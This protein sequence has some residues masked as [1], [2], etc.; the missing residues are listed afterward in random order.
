METDDG[1]GVRG[2]VGPAVR[3]DARPP[4]RALRPHPQ[5]RRRGPVRAGRRHV[6]GVRHQHARRRGA[7]PPAR[8][9]RG[10]LRGR[11]GRR[12]RRGVAARLVRL[13]RRAAADRR[14]GR[15]AL[16]AHPEDQLERH[17]PVPA[18]HVRLGG[19]RRHPDPHALPAR[20]HLQ[21]RA[22]RR[23]AGPCAAAVRARR[24]GPTRRWCRSAGATAAAGP[25]REMLAAAH[26]T[27]DLEGS[28]T[29]RLAR[30]TE[31][32]AAA[33]AEYPDPPVWVGELY[34]EYHR[35]T[36]TTQSRTKRGNRRSEH[37]LREAELW[38]T[39]AAVRR[40]RS[41]RSRRCAAAGRRCCCSSSTTSCPARRSRGCTGRPSGSTPASPT[42]WKG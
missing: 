35:G 31:F 17:Q 2:V 9:R 20:R 30:P 26:R 3:V 6:G 5:A 37:L 41:T 22:V 33:A 7:G 1:A 19:H 16:A 23:R 25:T 12:L 11:A 4:A 10:L 36:Y 28:P 21:R 27:R 13:L 34:L 40:A 18:P 8:A 32:F 39:T 24:G 29:V 15:A 14:R 38:A 42:S